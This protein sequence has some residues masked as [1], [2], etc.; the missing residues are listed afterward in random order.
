ML[1]TNIP[2][3]RS[4]D[5]MLGLEGT[6]L[7][8][9]PLG[10]RQ[11]VSFDAA[12]SA[13]MAGGATVL[14][15]EN[16]GTA[17][18][19]VYELRGSVLPR[20]GTLAALSALTLGGG[21]LC[22]PTDVDAIV[23]LRGASP[24]GTALVFGRVPV[25]LWDEDNQSITHPPGALSLSIYSRDA[26]NPVPVTISGGAATSGSGGSVLIQGGFSESSTGGGVT[27]QSGDCDFGSQTGDV[28]I[29]GLYNPVAS[30]GG[31]VYLRAAGTLALRTSSSTNVVQVNGA[32][33]A[34]GFFNSA[35]ATKPTVSGSRAGNAALASLLTAL[36]NLGLIT[37]ST[38]A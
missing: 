38:T 24:N 33:G 23:Q 32:S 13:L 16:T 22:H 15:F 9:V 27:I 20:S 12:T 7:V 5:A 29:I 6:N 35:G 11:P 10:D 30:G 26:A 18:A 19:P 14:T 25:G 1:P 21:E 2:E 36:A 31:N 28:E 8:R 37:N 17:Q 34:L 4:A 3:A